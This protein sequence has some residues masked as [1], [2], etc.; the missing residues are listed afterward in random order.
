MYVWMKEESKLLSK[1]KRDAIFVV[2]KFLI[3][4]LLENQK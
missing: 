1:V 2:S 4:I 3:E